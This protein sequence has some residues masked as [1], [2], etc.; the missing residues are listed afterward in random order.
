MSRG[1]RN[2]RS[3]AHTGVAERC[4]CRTAYNAVSGQKSEGPPLGGPFSLRTPTKGEK[5]S[6]RMARPPRRRQRPGADLVQCTRVSDRVA[7]VSQP[8]GGGHKG[9]LLMLAV[10][11]G[12]LAPQA[13]KQRGFPGMKTARLTGRRGPSP[14]ALDALSSGHCC[15]FATQVRFCRCLGCHELLPF[16]PPGPNPASQNRQ[17]K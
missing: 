2:T 9:T 14:N 11:R 6:P 15:P 16:A 12:Q 10:E 5:G 3:G 13:L 4:R 8:V 17:S 1:S 7:A